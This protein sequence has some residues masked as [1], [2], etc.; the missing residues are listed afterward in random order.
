MWSKSYST[1]VQ[2]ITAEQAWAVWIDVNQ[3]ASWQS[4]VEYA[5]LDTEFKNGATIEFKPKGGPRFKN[6]LMDVEAPVRFTDLAR[7]PLAKMY[8]T[9]EMIELGNDLQ[10]K[11]TVM[12]TGPLS[13]LWRKVV[14]E[15]IAEGFAGET[16]RFIEKIREK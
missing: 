14:V 10:I 16:M 7:F 3:W 5:K 2:G 6:Q 9:H 11:A 4:D 12:I 8:I 15:G 1:V 13:F